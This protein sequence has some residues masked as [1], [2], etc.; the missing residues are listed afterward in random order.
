MAWEFA[1]D[2]HN[3]N[4]ISYNMILRDLKLVLH[5]WIFGQ[6]LLPCE[7]SLMQNTVS[8]YT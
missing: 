1:F 6:K 8:K 7:E 4:R 3:R 2:E 5:V